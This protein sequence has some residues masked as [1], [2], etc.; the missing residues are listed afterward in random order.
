MTS[1]YNKDLKNDSVKMQIIQEYYGNNK[2]SYE[3][4]RELGIP[5][6]TIQNFLAKDT[7]RGWHLE[8]EEIIDKYF[9]GFGYEAPKEDTPDK[10]KHLENIEKAKKFY[11]PTRSALVSGDKLIRIPSQYLEEDV[12]EDDAEVLDSF[13]KC[14]ESLS[15]NEENG[16]L[17]QYGFPI[18]EG[19]WAGL[20]FSVKKKEVVD[21]PLKICIVADTQAKPNVSLEYMRWI[22]KYIFDKKPDIVVHIGDAYD[23]ESL[24][25]YDKGKKSFEG[26]RLK[27]DIEA[28]ND[29]LRLLLSEFQKDGYNPRLVF[30]MGNHEARFD[31]LADEMPELDGFVGT[32]TLPLAEMGWEVQP[33]LKPINIEGIFFVHYLANPMTGKPYGGTAMNQLKTVGNSFVVGHKQCLDVAIR[34]TLDGKHQIGI[35]NGAAYD[36]EEPYKGYTGNNHF[37]GITMLHEVK[38]SFGLPMFISLDYLKNRYEE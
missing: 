6:R 33:F 14:M 3:I 35:I 34:P 8:N 27:A 19:Q 20:G 1:I 13:L 21:K 4:S 17:N 16:V 5:A 18:P 2:S 37:R 11:D 29:S 9:N 7:H 31:R 15:K 25:S 36:F 32:D 26:R 10:L 23:F 28:G 22:G 24:S 38:D 30:C 12:G